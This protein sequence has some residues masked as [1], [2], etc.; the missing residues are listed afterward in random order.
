[1][2]AAPGRYRAGVSSQGRSYCGPLGGFPLGPSVGWFVLPLSLESQA[3]PYVSALAAGRRL[4]TDRF[5]S[6]VEVRSVNCRARPERM[7]AKALAAKPNAS[8]SGGW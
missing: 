8:C 7:E 5:R 2:P 4:T 1:M 3:A 6:T